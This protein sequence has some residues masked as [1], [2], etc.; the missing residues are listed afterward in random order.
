LI[1]DDTPQRR[2]EKETRGM[3]LVADAAT[4]TPRSEFD[5]DVHYYGLLSL[6][7][8]VLIAANAVFGRDIRGSRIS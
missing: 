5:F 3:M 8:A 1:I 2:L 6:L 4:L 7:T